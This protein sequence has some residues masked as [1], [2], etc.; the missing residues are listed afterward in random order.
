MPNMKKSGGY[1]LYIVASIAT[2]LYQ[3]IL[4]QNQGGSK[5]F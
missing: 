3:A 2:A 1:P 5:V 4:A